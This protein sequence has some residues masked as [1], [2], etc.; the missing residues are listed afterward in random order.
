M[1][2]LFHRMGTKKKWRFH[3]AD[4]QEWTEALPNPARGWYRIYTFEVHTEPRLDELEWCLDS[5]D[6][7]ALLILDIGAYRDR[8][9]EEECFLHIKKIL[10][11]F[12]DR[13]FDMILRVVYDHEGKG[14]EREPSSFNQVLRH[15]K[16]LGE[17]FSECSEAVFLWQG[18]L[19]GSWGEMHTSRFLADDKM[20]QMAKVMRAHRRP[21]MYLAVR[22]PVQ[23]RKLHECEGRVMRA[24]DDGMGLFDDGIFGSESNMGT[25]G[26]EEK[27]EA[28]WHNAW[29]RKEELAFEE[30]LCRFV[31][32]GGEAVLGEE[33]ATPLTCEKV[34]K[35]LGRMHVTYLNKA[36]DARLLEQWKKQLLPVEGPWQGRSLYDYVGAH[37]GYRFLIKKVA[38]TQAEG[39]NCLVE[40]GIEN[41]GFANCY[42]EVE[43]F[44]V[45]MDQLGNTGKVSLPC[46]IRTWERGRIQMV[47]G[48]VKIRDCRLFLAAG[49]K[50]D[51]AC[52]RFANR[53]DEAGRAVLGSL[54]L[55]EVK[56]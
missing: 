44:L 10:D 53:S 21:G 54:C 43:L 17:W 4:L 42:Q 47:S 51:G 35:T 41:T 12:E 52:I 46:D 5:D 1:K 28:G 26:S 22:R 45:W 48:L 23:W 29:C 31:P 11:F 19:V 33:N 24:P 20:G 16:Q 25:F 49:R 8:D 27:N 9:L 32:N 18:M 6:R 2:G 7:L 50:W 3:K 34:I 14:M 37:L 13:S 55:R 38:V 40:I 39:G 30:E 15:L 56:K 36:H